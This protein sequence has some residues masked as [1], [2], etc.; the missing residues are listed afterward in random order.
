[1]VTLY[2]LFLYGLG[3]FVVSIVVLAF[4]PGRRLTPPNVFLFVVGGFTGMGMAGY[5]IYL[6]FSFVGTSRIVGFLTWPTLLVGGLAGGIG[7]V[8]LKV[9][10]FHKSEHKR[11]AK[12][13]GESL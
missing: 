2:G 11:T 13:Q 9:R 1:M 5:V 6:I 10:F 12:R 4:F 8:C 7:L 3:F